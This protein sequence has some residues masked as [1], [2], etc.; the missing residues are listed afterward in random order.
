MFSFLFAMFRNISYR[1]VPEC[2]GT[3][4]YIFLGFFLLYRSQHISA[5]KT[6]EKVKGNRFDSS[7]C[8]RI[9]KKMDKVL[10]MYWMFTINNPANN[11]L[12]ARWAGCGIRCV[13]A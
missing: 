9:F 5:D 2:S 11:E 4:L 12:P 13:A 7:S 10:S 6:R 1:N 8:K 3:A